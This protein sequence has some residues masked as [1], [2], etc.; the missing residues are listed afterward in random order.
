[1]KYSSLLLAA[2]SLAPLAL[3]Q[4]PGSQRLPA[5]PCPNLVPREPLVL[6]EVTG[7]TLSGPI[8]YALTVYSD[9]AARLSSYLGEGGIGSGQLVQL[10]PGTVG[11]L[12]AGLE[13]AGALQACDQEGV[14]TDVPLQTLT[15]FRAGSTRRSNTFSWFWDDDLAQVRELLDDFIA[16]HFAPL[17]GE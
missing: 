6:Y 15:V 5:S 7:G 8:D 4:T 14:V 9:G 10:D 3:S 17:P 13:A 16:T 12:R 11:A 2:L 1:M